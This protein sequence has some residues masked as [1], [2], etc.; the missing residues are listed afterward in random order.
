MRRSI[1]IV[2]RNNF[3]RFYTSV[4]EEALSRG[5]DVEVWHDYGFPKNSSKGYS[6]PDFDLIPDVKGSDRIEKTAF[7]NVNELKNKILE[8]KDSDILFSL[9]PPCYYWRTESCK[10]VPK[11]ITLQRGL[12][13]FYDMADMSKNLFEPTTFAVYTD[14]WLHLGRDYLSKHSDLKDSRI[15]DK[16]STVVIGQPEFDVF[17]YLEKPNAVRK[18]YG[19]PQDKSILL[20]L[21]FPYQ[22]WNKKSAWEKA[23]AG[24]CMNTHVT[25][26]GSLDHNKKMPLYKKLIDDTKLMRTILQDPVASS[27]WR[28]GINEDRVFKSIK[29]FA[30]RNNLFLVAKPRLKFPVSQYIKENADLLVLDDE[31]QNMPQRL[32]ELLSVASL[33]FSYYSLSVFSAIFANV[34]HINI[35]TPKDFF[36]DDRSKYFFSEEAGSI[37]NY[38]GVTS[39]LSAQ[40]IISMLPDQGLEEYSMDSSARSRY[41]RE[42]IGFDDFN[43]SSRVFDLCLKIK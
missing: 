33:T 40:E 26:A 27:Y 7:S 6:F 14:K 20:Y 28:K 38:E 39:C 31:S 17:K 21:P 22:N 9:H 32:K 23:F 30:Q 43:S 29:M 37:F 3:Y 2:H 4:L 16:L 34:Y 19:I 11:W 41:I 15:L 5:Y 24:L 1:F 13:S 10:L 42:Y 18:K 35:T 8:L 25:K 36:P 12:D